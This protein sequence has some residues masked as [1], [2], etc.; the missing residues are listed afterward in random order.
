MLM[1]CAIFRFDPKA[2]IVSHTVVKSSVQKAIRSK[3]LEAYPANQELVENVLLSKK[4][5]LVLYKW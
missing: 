4:K 1:I 3:L 2:D 5:D